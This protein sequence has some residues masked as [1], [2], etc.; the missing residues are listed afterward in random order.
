MP[1]P[2]DPFAD[3]LNEVWSRLEANPTFTGKVAAANRIKFTGDDGAPNK[4]N[5]ND[6]DV[7]LVT[8]RLA[9]GTLDLWAAND[10]SLVAQLVTIELKTD[11]ARVQANYGQLKWA[12]LCTL[13]GMENIAASLDW[14]VAVNSQA[15]TDSLAAN[16]KARQDG[17]A[18]ILTIRFDCAFSRAAMVEAASI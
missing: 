15:H 18:T 10:E 17:W 9:G 6:A 11:D 14:V 8:V 12:I 4:T 2:T 1:F 16:P 5:H 13:A 3:I 7:P